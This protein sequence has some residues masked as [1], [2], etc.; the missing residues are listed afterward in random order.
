V[1]IAFFGLP[2]A[3]YL[4]A[5]DGHALELAVLSPVEAPGRRRLGRTLDANR[6]LDALELGRDLERQVEAQLSDVDLVVS[7]YWTRLLPARWLGKGR[8]GAIGVHPS[9][10]PRHRGPNPFF[11]AIDA[12]DERT[13]VSVHRL[14]ERYDDGDVLEQIAIPVGER[15]AWQLA[16]ALDRPSLAALRHV[17]G[18]LAR[19]A[20]LEGRAQ[21]ESLATWAP[22]PEGDALRV[23]F[24]WPTERVLR[25]IRALSPVPGVALELE[26]F[27]FFLTRAEPADAY[28]GGLEPGEAATVGDPPREVVIRTGDGAIRLRGGVAG[29][30]NRC[31]EGEPV[32]PEDLAVLVASRNRAV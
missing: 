6:I 1:R 11:W 9:L 23:D 7:W 29:A 21:D 25:R 8:L 22:E 3:A 19:G 27:S 30:G 12:G 2:L 28:P 17:V 20:H 4:L 13:G 16:R 14:T 15:D 24:H 18:E 10:L 26:G 32:R 31:E 5:R